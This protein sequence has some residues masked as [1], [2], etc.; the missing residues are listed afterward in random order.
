M[1]SYLLDWANLLVRWLH[2]IAGIAWIG[3]SFYFVMLDTSLKPPKKAADKQR[4][5]F[6]ELWAVHGGGF[7]CSQK[8]LTGP[9]GEPLSQDLH[10]SKWEAY[11]TW[12]SG[13]GM[14][15]IVYWAGA[16]SYLIDRNVMALT[17]PAAI[18]LSIGFLAA[19]WVVY[20]LL[21]R[22]L[23]GRD[24]L[25]AGLI[26]VLVVFADWA[27]HQVFSARAAYLHVGA[28]LG[29]I[30][31]ANVFVHIIPGQKR[32]VAQI[33]AG[34]PV[35]P[36]PGQI[37]KQRSVH[38]TYFTLPVLFTMI[39]NHYPM[40]YSHANG[41]L[42]LVVMMAAGVLIRQFFVLR[43]RGQV[44]WWLPA[45]GV[46]LL[47]LLVVLMAPEKVDAGGDKV[48]FAQVK[49]VVDQRCI[50]CHAAQPT[51]EGFIQPPKGVLLQTPEE[52]GQHAAKIAETVASGYM[53]LGNLTHITD[54][55]RRLIATWHAQGA[56]LAD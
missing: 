41:W 46:A 35:D 27:L 2:L 16:S 19:G 15:A 10:W 34:R 9:Q 49:Q 25:L 30:M 54:E 28:V 38:N 3:A 29:T 37:G 33:R 12:L 55:E 13:M 18:A 1:E 52:I 14:L 45:S 48:A 17:P 5:V 24:A 39:S 26:F 6:G 43:H 50:A 22:L 32:M 53:P 42:V 21:C 40:T 7:Y 51:Y 23:V 31:A 47:A 56:R 8:F 36:R 44:K 11:T 4:G 20:D